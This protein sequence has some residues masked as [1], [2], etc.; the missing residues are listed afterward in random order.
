M[1]TGAR[2]HTVWLQSVLLHHTISTDNKKKLHFFQGHCSA[3]SRSRYETCCH[4]T[5]QLQKVL[6]I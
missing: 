6:D 5:E 4:I 1:H 3:A 2:M